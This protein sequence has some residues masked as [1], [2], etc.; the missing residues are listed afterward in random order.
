MFNCPEATHLTHRAQSL[1]AHL[2]LRA[3]LCR[4]TVSV[5][6]Q[7]KKK[8]KCW[9]RVAIGGYSRR[10]NAFSAAEAAVASFCSWRLIALLGLWR[11][12]WRATSRTTQETEEE[13]DRAGLDTGLFLLLLPL[14]NADGRLFVHLQVDIYAAIKAAAS[15]PT[16][17]QPWRYQAWRTISPAR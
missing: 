12:R 3:A 8:K 14:L 15:P 5:S 9:K 16:P 2:W 11:F 13:S 1:C 7:L 17:Q 10:I 4:R 6:A